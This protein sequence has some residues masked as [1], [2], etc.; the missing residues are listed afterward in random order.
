MRRLSDLKRDLVK[1][2][3]SLRLFTLGH[4]GATQR[5]GLSQI[6]RMRVLCE[7]INDGIK[8]GTYAREAVFA[9]NTARGQI[10]AAEA[11]LAL[12]RN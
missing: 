12:L 8:S 1:L 2:G 10:L 7:R 3:Q 9:V 6:A 5:D 4:R 11:R